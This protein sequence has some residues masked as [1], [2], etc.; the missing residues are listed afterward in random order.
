MK[1]PVEYPVT[2]VGSWP[3]PAWLLDAMK[4]KSPSLDELKDQATL[5]AIKYQEDAG[6]DVIAD[7]EQRRDN[8]YSFI[9]D[10][11]EGIRLMTLAELL[12]YVEDKAAFENL[13]NALDVP[14]FAIKNPVVVGKVRRRAPL[15]MNDY[16]FLREH[17]RKPV[18]ITLPGPYLLSRSTWVK[19]L[20]E[21]TY[22]D[23]DSLGTD[24]VAVLREELQ[25]L[26]SAGADMVQ[27]DEPVLSEL[28]LA[29][30]SA[31]RTFMCAA[32]AASS[33]P[34]GELERAVS[35]LNRVIDGIEGPTL[36]VHVCRGNW[37]RNEDVLLAGPYDGLVPYLNRMKLDQF[38]LEYATA[39]A[40]SPQ[41]LAQLQPRAQIGYGVVN[42][43]T[44]EIETPDEIV[45]RVR[46]L[47]QFVAPE[48]IFLNP[49]CGFGTFAERPVAEARTAFAKLS[50]L[51][52]AARK[53]RGE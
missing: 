41:A 13:L 39:R 33:S 40:G 8:F 6:V 47:A 48:R 37:S 52:A 4:R 34:E 9:A 23:G 43:R 22:P 30:R 45:A 10:R 42:P 20:S 16:R 18:K 1:S 21:S 38:V 11:L 24:I 15:V 17:T 29:G 19:G 50:S 49:D 7:G 44:A 14:A 31:T 3:R 53:L 32:L 36:C 12:D 2:V 51:S 25:E 27:F 28:L 46:E 5:L 35:L 26:A